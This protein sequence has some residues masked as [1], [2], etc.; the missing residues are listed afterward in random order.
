M[1][2]LAQFGV[3]VGVGEAKFAF[4]FNAVCVRLKSL[5]LHRLYYL[6]LLNLLAPL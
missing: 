3:P 1:L 2:L 6:R 4:K 5:Y